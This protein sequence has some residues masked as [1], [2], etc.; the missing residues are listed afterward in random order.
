MLAVPE[1][2]TIKKKKKVIKPIT[3]VKKVVPVIATPTKAPTATATAEPPLQKKP[4]STWE[5]A[6]FATAKEFND[7]KKGQVAKQAK[8]G[9]GRF[10]EETSLKRER[11]NA[12]KQVQAPPVP[13]GPTAEQIKERMRQAKLQAAKNRLLG[14]RDKGISDLNA[15]SEALARYAE[16]RRGQADVNERMSRMAREKRMAGIGQAGTGLS[17]QGQGIETLARANV[18]QGINEQEA[19]AKADIKKRISE[20][21]MSTDRGIADAQT[22]SDLQG[23]QFELERIVRKENQAIKQ[24]QIN[25]SRQYDQYI[26]ELDKKDAY[27]LLALK[28][29]LQREDT[30][31]ANEI[32]IAEEERDF[33]RV[34]ELTEIKMQNDY[35]MT[36]ID[37]RNRMKQIGAQGAQQR[38]TAAQRHNQSMTEIDQRGLYTGKTSTSG[39]TE[40]AE[41]DYPTKAIQ[42][43]ITD[44]VKTRE[45]DAKYN[46]ESLSAASKK[47]AIMQSILDNIELIS[48]E[49]QLAELLKD[50]LITAEEIAAYKQA[51]MGQYRP[52]NQ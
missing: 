7:Y 48:S 35:K 16:D 9:G 52:G 33:A 47:D 17:E 41:P 39:T 29:E 1:D 43:A 22:A 6:G 11:E 31:I 44:Y 12:A 37:N 2:V 34:K 23:L 26:R 18:E 19:L 28:T 24:M 13:Q 14:L 49:E 51:R 45:A 3:T 10:T 4:V 30:M 27:E 46:N 5:Q 38:A 32:R 8:Y 15:D 21:N 20:L 25:D 40:P 42:G 36:E 50:N